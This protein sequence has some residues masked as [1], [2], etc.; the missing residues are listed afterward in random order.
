M[1][2]ICYVPIFFRI[3]HNKNNMYFTVYWWYSHGSP[4]THGILSICASM[5]IPLCFAGFCGSH[6]LWV[7][8]Y[9]SYA[10]LAIVLPS[11]WSTILL[12]WPKRDLWAASWRKVDMQMIAI[13]RPPKGPK[14][15]GWGGCFFQQKWHV[16]NGGF[17]R[18]DSRD[19]S[20]I[21]KVFCQVKMES[22]CPFLMQSTFKNVPEN[23]AKLKEM[24]Q[25]LDATWAKRFAK[26]TVSQSESCSVLVSLS[27][28][29][30]A[31]STVPWKT[32]PKPIFQGRMLCIHTYLFWLLFFR[33]MYTYGIFFLSWFHSF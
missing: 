18:R 28:K 29:T 33:C 26:H 14:T 30:I 32:T 31:P 7:F 5:V 25:A 21:C 23:Y 4:W 20:W 15:N 1:I 16:E 2:S 12:L 9:F 24:E 11:S 17:L 22:S 19:V 27:P 13:L 10:R 3:S 6:F 8:R